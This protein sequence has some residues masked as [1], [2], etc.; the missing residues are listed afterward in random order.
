MVNIIYQIALNELENVE[1]D[2]CEI[3]TSGIGDI[4]EFAKNLEEKLKKHRLQ[5]SADPFRR[6]KPT[7][8]G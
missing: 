7:A 4:L 8:Q 2:F 1:K 3:V 5:S 6:P